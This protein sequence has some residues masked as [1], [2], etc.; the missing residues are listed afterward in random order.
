MQPI[1]KI[2]WRFLQQSKIELSYDQAIPLP[3]LYPNKTKTRI[4]KVIYTP[5][6]IA[7]LFPLAKTWK[8]LKFTSTDEWIKKMW[9][10]F[11]VEYYTVMLLPFATWMNLESIML[12]EISQMEKEK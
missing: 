8:Q 11:I 5:T 2:V 7:A 12:S 6:F 10:N 1:W 4:R 3:G 9:Y